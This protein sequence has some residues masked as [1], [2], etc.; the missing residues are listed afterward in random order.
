LRCQTNKDFLER[1]VSPKSYS[2][3]Y[4]VSPPDERLWEEPKD[5][6][7]APEGKGC[8]IRPARSPGD[9]MP[10]ESRFMLLQDEGGGNRSDR[11]RSGM[12]RY[13]LDLCPSTVQPPDV[14]PKVTTQEFEV[15]I[16]VISV[17]NINVFKDFGQRNDLF[18]QLKYKASSMDGSETNRKEKT[19]V[20]RWAHQDASFN[21]RFIFPLTG[22]CTSAQIEFTLF[23]FDRVTSADMVYYPQVYSLDHL[24]QLAYRNWKDGREPISQLHED[25]TFDSWPS[26]NILSSASTSRFCSCCRR[27]RKIAYLT[28]AA[29]KAFFAKLHITVEVVPKE[30]ADAMPVVA[31][32]FSPPKDRLSVQMLATNPVK[33]MKVM[34]GPRLYGLMRTTVI[35]I[36]LLLATLLILTV[37]YYIVTLANDS[38]S[39]HN[40][41]R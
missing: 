4:M 6:D 7:V 17:D 16:S 24:A 11:S 14:P 25:V 36:L 1:N 29:N 30:Y 20:H 32:Q 10:I 26:K 19:D 12:L 2:R 15:R 22:P 35:L 28:S 8:E 13:C 18:V 3:Y 27:S 5:P 23:D 9:R 40:S 21:Q 33:T 31:G 39:L 41:A 37:V 34:L 38:V